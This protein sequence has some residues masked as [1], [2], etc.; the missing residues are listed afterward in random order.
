MVSSLVSVALGAEYFTD[1]PAG[2]VKPCAGHLHSMVEPPSLAAGSSIP[3]DA[4]RWQSGQAQM[5]AVE[6]LVATGDSKI[7]HT[8]RIPGN[9]SA[10]VPVTYD[11]S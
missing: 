10:S 1:E 5:A 9:A 2:A 6:P 8:Q 7:A 4:Q 11:E 3:K